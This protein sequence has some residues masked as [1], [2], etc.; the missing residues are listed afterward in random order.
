MRMSSIRPPYPDSS[1]AWHHIRDRF[2]LIKV[3]NADETTT[4]I[5]TIDVKSSGDAVAIQSCNDKARGRRLVYVSPVGSLG[6]GEQVL[7]EVARGAR[8]VGYSVSFICLRPGEFPDRLRDDRFATSVF[9]EHRFRNLWTVHAGRAFVAEILRREKADLAHVNHTGWIYCLKAKCPVVLHV[10]DYPYRFDI[11]DLVHRLWKPRNV[12]FTSPHVRS[13]YPHLHQCPHSTTILP[14]ISSEAEKDTSD[15]QGQNATLQAMKLVPNRY[16]LTVARLQPHKGLLDFLH[17]IRLTGDLAKDFVF[18]IAGKATGPLQL[19]H[20]RELRDFC[21]TNR[22]AHQV[23]FLGFVSD[24]ELRILYRNAYSLIHP[25]HSEGFGLVVLEAMRHGLPIITTD[26]EGPKLMVQDEV[27]GLVCRVGDAV[28]LARSIS[29]LTTSAQLRER[30]A[31]EALNKS[32][33]YSSTRM[34]SETLAFYENILASG[35]C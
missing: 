1:P 23:R 12:I 10:H 33:L 26:A 27:S 11:M 9:Q 28:G 20:E 2:A 16:F 17:A 35:P 5:D 21:K 29:K 25:A 32:K 13:G 18:A 6:G 4:H 14:V 24:S 19:A 34:V 30:M 15:A 31:K 3:A 7:H 8:R 22:M